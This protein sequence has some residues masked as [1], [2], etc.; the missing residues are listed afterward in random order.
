MH[1]LLQQMIYDLPANGK[2]LVQKAQGYHMTIKA[3]VITYENGDH[4]G[5][6]P[7]KLIKGGQSQPAA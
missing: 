5:A 6:L 2:R 3:G 7:R 1:D 4:T